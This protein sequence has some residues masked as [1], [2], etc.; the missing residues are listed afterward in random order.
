MVRSD[1]PRLIL[2]SASPRRLELLAQI[3]IRPAEIRPADIDE[4]PRTD[5]RARDYVRRMASQKA[6][7]LS[8]TQG[9][10]A[11]CADT[12]VAVGRRILG[13]PADRAEAASFMR[14]MAGRRHRVLTAVAIREGERIRERLVETIV[15]MRPITPTEL[16]RYLDIGDWQGKAGAYAIQGAAAAFIPWIS[17][18]H[19]A[20]V[21]LPLSETAAMLSAS[22]ILP[23]AA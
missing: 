7:A 16:D 13:K 2:G 8:L 5:E 3:G 17:G 22:G 6:A 9:E 1:V 23:E 15:R 4:T 14:L 20:V 18:S 11:L 21:G 10:I 19:S 12:T